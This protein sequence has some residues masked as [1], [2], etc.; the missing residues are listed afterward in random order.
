MRKLNR[1]ELTGRATSHVHEFAGPGCI[2]HARA[3]EALLAMR[4]AARTAGVDLK[5]VSGF[6]DFKR[7][8]AIWAAKFNGE[9][10]LLD[11][12]GRE[13]RREGLA[14]TGLIDSILIWSALPG[15]SRHHWGSEIDVIDAAGVTAGERVRLVPEEFAV[16]GCFGRLNGWLEGNMGRFGFY[17]PYGTDRGGVSPEPWH[18]SYAPVSFGALGELSLEVLEEAIAGADMPGRELVLSRLPE[19]YDRYVLAVDPP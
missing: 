5:V 6:R 3:G 18:L 7:Q 1:F 16:G 12:A 15:G 10:P 2:L 14:E 9:R 19:L 4:A 8:V 17:R 11:R 13:I